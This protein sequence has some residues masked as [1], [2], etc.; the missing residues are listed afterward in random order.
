M[1]MIGSHHLVLL[2]ALAAGLL[3]QPASSRE[4]VKAAPQDE[5]PTQLI[6]RVLKDVWKENKLT[7]PRKTTDAEF[8]KKLYT[9]LTGKAPTAAQVAAFENDKAA[10]KRAKL[11]EQLLSEKEF[12]THRAALLSNALLPEKYNRSYRDEFRKWLAGRIAGNISYAD[13]VKDMLTAH[14]KTTENG[15]VHFILANV[16]TQFPEEKRADA[17][18]FDMVPVTAATGQVFLGLGFQCLACH[19]HPFD[20]SL[21]QRDFWGINS[22]F[23][24]AERIGEPCDGAAVPLELKENAK[25]NAD[26][27][28]RFKRRTGLMDATGMNFLNGKGPRNDDRSRRAVLAEYVTK[29]PNFA[30]VAVDRTWSTLLSR[31]LLENGTWHDVG[32]FNEPL[33]PELLNGL[34]SAFQESGHDQKKLIA[35]ICNSD[36]YQLHSTIVEEDDRFFFRKQKEQAVAEPDLDNPCCLSRYL[37]K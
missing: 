30:P 6:N 25:L 7:P 26:G 24:Q 32:D 35:W 5:S 21:R 1:A 27:V 12:A 36:V 22:F 16:G 37:S 34:A 20:A 14:G 4:P 9:D 13:T 17:G 33:Y 19:S 31:G 15:A 3:A 18:Q 29:H 23:R 2:A 11:I 8:A 10:D 28:V